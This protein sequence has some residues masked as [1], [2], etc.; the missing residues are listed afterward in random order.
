MAICLKCQEDYSD[1]R[2]E[3]GFSTCLS[4]GDIA[5]SKE[6]NRRKKCLAPAYSKGAYQ[7]VY[8]K[9]D[10]LWAGRAK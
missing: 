7:L 9:N 6:A 10:A 1:K 8:D 3:L 5:A 2:R 4:C